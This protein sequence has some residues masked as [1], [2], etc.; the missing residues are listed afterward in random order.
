MAE[1]RNVPSLST[2]KIITDPTLKAEKLL[3][4]FV[5]SLKD[6]SN[7]FMDS[8]SSLKYL[9]FSYSDSPIRFKEE[10]SVVLEAYFKRHYTSVSISIE[11][12]N[13]DDD[14]K[15]IRVSSVGIRIV[16]IDNNGEK[17]NFSKTIDLERYLIKE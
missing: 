9:V 10:L 4:Y 8:I 14:N 16:A 15:V 11:L 17:I 13:A 6:Q 2:S 3:E 5:A 1:I 12:N 7:Y